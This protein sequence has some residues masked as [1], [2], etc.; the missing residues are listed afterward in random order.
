[1]TRIARRLSALFLG[2]ATALAGTVASGDAHAAGAPPPV[3]S[4]V[5]VFSD[6]GAMQFVLTPNG[7]CTWG[8]PNGQRTV[9]SC[10]WRPTNDIGGIVVMHY[11]NVY[12]AQAYYSVVWSNART[13]S[14]SDPYFRLIMH[15]QF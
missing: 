14:F 1:M 4:W 9:G 10:E 3:G 5:G 2:L 12:P 15:P 13:I 6:G 11:T 8:I 7:T